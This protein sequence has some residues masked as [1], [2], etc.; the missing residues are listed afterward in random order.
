MNITIFLLQHGHAS[1]GC[2]VYSTFMLYV[3]PSLQ[4]VFFNYLERRA[5][6]SS[7]STH[8]NFPVSLS[9]LYCINWPII[10]SSPSSI[11]QWSLGAFL[12]VSRWV[13]MYSDLLN[14][15]LKKSDFFSHAS[16]NQPG[17]QKHFLRQDSFTFAKSS[18]I[19]S[20]E[21]AFLSLLN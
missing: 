21:N 13:L 6:S 9:F 12:W 19:E 3:D 20:E 15:W 11:L 16:P 5:L 7:F 4:S 8:R 10:S 14:L 1:K 18:V 2:S 17:E